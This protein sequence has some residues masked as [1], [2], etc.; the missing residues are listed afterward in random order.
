MKLKNYNIKLHISNIVKTKEFKIRMMSFV[1]PIFLMMLIF[2]AKNIFPFGERSFLRTDLYHQY[3]P[4]Y[5]E[6]LYKLQHGKSL[7]YTYDVGLG[8]NFISLFAYYLSSPLNLLLFFVNE[9]YIIEFI[10]YIVV[11]KIGLCGYTMSEYLINKFK[12]NKY[13]VVFF[14]LFY[15]M[16]GYMAAYYWNVMWLDCIWL[17]P[18]VVLGFEKVFYHNDYLLYIITLSISI[19]TNYYIALMIC[20][21]LVIYFIVLIILHNIKT[22]DTLL[23]KIRNVV[24]YSVISA[25][26]SSILLIPTIC[27]FRTTGSSEFE[28]PQVYTEYFQIIDVISRHLPLVKIENGLAHW[29]N[30]YC[31]TF[32]FMLIP[33]YLMNKKYS[34]KEKITYI[35]LLIFFIASFSINIINFFWHIMRYPNSLPA[36]QSFIYVFLVLIIAFKGLNKF[37]NINIKQLN[38]SFIIGFSLIIL[39]NK[40]VI[41]DKTKFQSFY[42][43]LVMLIIIYAMLYYYKKYSKN[44]LY[45]FSIA[46]AILSFESFINMYDTSIST[47]NRQSYVKKWED[48]KTLTKTIDSYTSEFFRVEMNNRTAKDDGAFFNY[49]SASIFSSSTYK[50]G[51]DFYK[52]IGMETSMNAYSVTGSTPF[53]DSL[54]S[55]KY[56]FYDNEEENF[57]ELNMRLISSTDSM[58]VY[59]HLDTLPFS[60]VLSDDFIKDYNYDVANPATAQNNFAR[61]LNTKLLLSKQDIVIDGINATFKVL[62][63]GNYYGFVR[64]KS[65]EKVVV[66]YPTTQK[67]F[68]NLSRGYFME[69][70]YLKSGESYEFR[71]NTNEKELLLE[72]F[73]FNYDALKEINNKINDNGTMKMTY[74]DD[75]HINFDIDS[76]IDGTCLITLPYDKGFTLY[77]DDERVKT[78]QVF[79]FFLGFDI[80]EGQHK[81]RLVYMPVG[82]I[83]GAIMSLIG[84][85][86]LIGL[87]LYNKKLKL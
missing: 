8:N 61:T 17:F 58:F 13:Y 50:S 72:I 19:L 18:L 33:L 76:K 51:T 30:I 55:V 15:A 36:R 29:P 27:A 24:I 57:N 32:V 66:N 44:Y 1:I 64:D 87:N 86:S 65:I 28:F 63:D 48:V 56:E 10:T 78:K 26:I 22:V 2:I 70:G 81:I 39:L 47:I 77:V 79:D 7:L 67:E 38:I 6:L 25:F 16:S 52:R 75:T 42:F 59:Q 41:N 62:E 54:L 82:L 21:F 9:K 45:I 60:Y 68:D 53:A 83:L 12:S 23:I 71:N 31:G 20:I 14:A 43:A 11:F 4:F 69:L 73:K 80:E 74:Y 3:A 5:S 37:K 35:V 46:I 49:P 34:I 85:I 84:I 40:L